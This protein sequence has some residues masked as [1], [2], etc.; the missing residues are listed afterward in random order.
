[1]H[2]TMELEL[3]IGAHAACSDGP[4]GKL[5]QVVLYRATDT[6]THLVI[7][8]MPHLG[9]AVLVPRW[10][11]VSA[12]HDHVRLSCTQA[13]LHRMEPFEDTVFLPPYDPHQT[14]G[15]GPTDY[16]YGGGTGSMTVGMGQMGLGLG[17]MGM[18]SVGW[19][20]TPPFAVEEHLPPAGSV[21]PGAATPAGTPASG[22]SAQTYAK[23][24]T[25]V[26][27]FADNQHLA[28]LLESNGVAI[29]ASTPSAG[30]PLLTLLFSFGP[31]IL[32]IGG[33]LWLT[34]RA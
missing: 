19:Q 33:F 29:M 13:E 28:T 9:F 4:A 5:R 26:P 3:R 7:N 1:M 18:G 15:Y 16:F 11:V 12:D 31:T 6:V 32:L 27:S 14:L 2:T 21:A 25:D 24:S 17:P 22:Q 34:T 23:F 8:T 30:S 10:A 20:G